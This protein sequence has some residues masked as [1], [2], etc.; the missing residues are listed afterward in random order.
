LATQKNSAH[1]IYAG[2]INCH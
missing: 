2:N 1:F